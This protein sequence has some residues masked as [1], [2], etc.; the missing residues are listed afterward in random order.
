MQGWCWEC[1]QAGAALAAGWGRAVPAVGMHLHPQKTPPAKPCQAP[2]T[3]CFPTS[4][5]AE[6]LNKVF[7]GTSLCVPPG[8]NLSDVL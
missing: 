1:P 4:D 6:I 7:M 3:H 8:Y 2:W 5:L